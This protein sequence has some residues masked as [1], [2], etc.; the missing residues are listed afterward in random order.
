MCPTYSC[1]LI[2]W[3]DALRKRA[4]LFIPFIRG[5]RWL[6]TMTQY[7]VRKVY[8]NLL[9]YGVL[10]QHAARGCSVAEPNP[11][12]PKSQSQYSHSGAKARSRSIH[13]SSQFLELPEGS[14]FR[15]CWWDLDLRLG[16]DQI[17]WFRNEDGFYVKLG[18]GRWIV[19][20]G[21]CLDACY[22]EHGW[23]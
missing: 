11:P 12:E 15:V 4:V 23:V 7:S 19:Q 22:Y 3:P 13:L 2:K 17:I 21:R 20:F 14:K 8:S 18:W 16:W 6:C 9:N 10:V 5:K 1:V